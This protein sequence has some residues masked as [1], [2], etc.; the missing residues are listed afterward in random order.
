MQKDRNEYFKKYWKIPEHKKNH[1]VAVK[2]H[3]QNNIN[4]GKCPKC[5]NTPIF[6]KLQCQKCLD[7]LKN[8]TNKRIANGMCRSHPNEPLAP[9]SKSRCYKCLW[10]GV[11]G[12]CNL[13]DTEA[14]KILEKQNYICPISGRKLIKG[15]NT[16]PDHIV[17][18]SNGGTHN[19]NNIR[20]VDIMVQ[21][22]RHTWTDEGL[23]KFVKDVYKHQKF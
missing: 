3:Q 20:F 16:S 6:G 4:N 15:I 9:G 11:I 23:F 17:H 14:S 8:N 21:R 5:G 22:C 12:H 7:R 1:I 19:P 10:E 18:Q 2:K 13:T